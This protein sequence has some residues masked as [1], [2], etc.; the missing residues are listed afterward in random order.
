MTNPDNTSPLRTAAETQLAATAETTPTRPE[1][2]LLHD[3]QVHQIEM[4]MQNEALRQ[5]LTALE[6]AHDRYLDLYEFA[7]VGYLTLS[8]QGIIEAINLTGT[9]LLGRERSGLL[10][11]RFA[12]CVAP[13]D[14]DAW[15][16]QFQSVKQHA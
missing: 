5:T 6:E 4:E 12:A 16:R 7:P 15:Q 14:R 8:S 13:A 2:D 9:R 1:A 10:H 3:L 11:Y